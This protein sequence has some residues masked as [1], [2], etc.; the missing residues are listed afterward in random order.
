G[1]DPPG[2]LVGASV[3]ALNASLIAAHPSLAGAQM[4]RQVWCSKVARDVLRIHPVSSL[5]AGVRRQLNTLPSAN[6]LRLIESTERLTGIST[7]E[8][9]R[10]P[11]GIV[12]TDVE[13]GVPEVFRSGPLTP[14]LLASTAIPGVFPAVRVGDRDFLDG[15]IVDNTPIAVAVREGAKQVLAVHLMAGGELDAPPRTWSELITRTLQLSLHHRM[16]SDFER[17][18]SA[19]RVVVLAPVL[20]MRASW[21]MDL[22]RGSAIIDKARAAT[23]RLLEVEGRRLWR[24]SAVHYLELGL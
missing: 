15:G 3:G 4:L 10:R 1:I 8:Q 21:Q 20:P 2:R 7:F 24:R 12:A 22:A 9:L 6:V 13:A 5:L 18:K 23:R 19:A 16:L 14:A 11:L 17:L